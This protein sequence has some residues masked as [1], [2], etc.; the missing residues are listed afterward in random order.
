M[1]LYFSLILLMLICWVDGMAQKA[2]RIPAPLNTVYEEREPILSPDGKQL[3]VWRRRHPG[4]AGGAGDQGDIWVSDRLEDF[5]YSRPRPFPYK[6]NSSGLDF[7][8]QV[9]A[10]GD[11][12]FVS[13]VLSS[14][15]P[16]LYYT[17][18]KGNEIGPLRRLYVQGFFPRGKHRDYVI[19]TQGDMLIPNETIDGFGGPDL[20]VSFRINDTTW[21]RPVNLG[22]TIN[23]S[24]DED[25]PFLLPDGKTLFFNSNG[26]NSN[27]KHDVY[28]STRLDDTW[29]NWSEPQQIGAPINSPENEADFVVTDD[30]EMAYWISDNEAL[31][32][33]DIYQMRM[34]GCD[35]DVYPEGDHVMCEGESMELEVGFTL[36]ERELSYQWQRDGK[37]IPGET[38]RR[39]VVRETGRYQVVRIKDD[40]R[41]TSLP[42]QVTVIPSPKVSIETKTNFICE[43]D[44][45]LL[46]ANSPEAAS[47][48]WVKNGL[49]IPRANRPD[50]W[51]K[52]PGTYYV[53]VSNGTCGSVTKA[54][55]IGKMERPVIYP[56]DQALVRARPL[57]N[58]WLWT[59]E[60]SQKKEKF[61]TQ[62]MS[63]D[64]DG[65]VVVLG[66]ENKG[67]KY[68]PTLIYFDS[69]G[70]QKWKKVADKGVTSLSNQWVKMDYE[71]NIIVLDADQFLTKYDPSGR[72]LWEKRNDGQ[73]YPAGLTT[74]PLGHVYAFV[75]YKGEV[76]LAGKKMP[77]RANG[78]ACIQKF[79]P[80]GELKWSRVITTAYNESLRGNTLGCDASGN[81]YLAGAF[82]ERI[83][84]DGE[85]ILNAVTSD[86]N[87]YIARYFPDGQLHWARRYTSPTF[88]PKATSMH[89]D[90]AGNTYFLFK[91]RILKYDPYGRTI[92]RS[93]GDE[94]ARFAS[95]SVDKQG[96][97]FT[98]NLSENKQYSLQRTDKRGNTIQIWAQK[99]VAKNDNNLPVLSTNEQGRL[100]LACLANGK[101]PSQ[102]DVGELPAF[103]TAFGPPD[104]PEELAP[105]SL[106][107]GES[108]DMIVKIP[109]DLP[110][111][112]LRD[113]RPIQGATDTL[114][115]ITGRGEYTVRAFSGGCEQYANVQ[116]V[117]DCYQALNQPEEPEPKP[118]KEEKVAK[119]EPPK[120]VIKE[121]PPKKEEPKPEKPELDAEIKT[122]LVGA[123]STINNRKVNRQGG[124]RVSNPKV[125]I[126]IWDRGAIDNDTV[127][128]NV[129]GKWLIEDYALR[130][131][132]KV[133]EVEFVPGEANYI[134]LY[135]HN[136][137]IF[138]PNTATISIDDG[139]K[140]KVFKLK[141]SLDDCGS[142]NVRLDK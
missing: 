24:G 12:F 86:A 68:Y 65:N 61:S 96:T 121:E 44:S 46:H 40:C 56:A 32:S 88:S 28:F 55:R 115:K 60:F 103:V 109:S 106:C 119:P 14:R 73:T 85:E 126:S 123:P 129:N 116:I 125:K 137:G 74:D 89:T 41:N 83:I 127:S 1:K 26:H 98:L 19:T 9:S 3:F 23:S 18:K 117:E 7:L 134:I 124:V 31:G 17:I 66:M 52:R 50:L 102:A 25:A 20:F 93:E 80:W 27:G 107:P 49:S 58:E 87:A 100:F 142:I 79:D 2:V 78:G 90:P 29:Q 91:G 97:L 36:A 48:E 132:P 92:W 39:L 47:W 105:I 138:P 82:S 69:E 131:K 45:I 94:N 140:T 104:H 122:N 59:E 118:Q 51:V 10:T 15:D 114:L 113:G 34:R 76:S 42:T 57:P 5:R 22:P 133:F 53:K 4:N 30:G 135:A 62:D 33:Y 72:T 35:L 37:D 13:Q 63:S 70:K 8:W 54:I 21:G 130:K 11:T 43:E 71:G 99:S 16:G 108:F 120:V 67:R 128:L 136:L 6:L 38:G 110:Y 84:F 95:I 75:R 77:E 139:I 141:S 111:Y 101:A 81:L 112:W 64:A